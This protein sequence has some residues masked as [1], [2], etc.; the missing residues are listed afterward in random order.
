[1]VLPIYIEMIETP[2]WEGTKAA[3]DQCMRDGYQAAGELWASKML[4]R[5][6]TPAAHDLYHYQ[7][8]SEKT[9]KRKLA[10]FRAGKAIM[11]GT[12]D[13]VMTGL[14][15]SAVKGHQSIRAM[16]KSVTVKMFGPRYLW[17]FKKG[18]QPDKAQEIT[19]VIE[20]ETIMIGDVLKDKYVAGVNANHTTKTTRHGG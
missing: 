1:M 10:A 11:D 6:F 4:P 19:T 2:P 8:R 18:S 17:A 3:H 5:H 13:N 15:A 12:T 14:M 9:K 20:G 7:A 16:P